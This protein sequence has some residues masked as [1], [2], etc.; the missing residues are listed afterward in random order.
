MTRVRSRLRRE[1][2]LVVHLTTTDMSLD[3]LLAPQLR[4]FADAGYDVVGMSA[5]GSH[6]A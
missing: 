6:V 3:W 2:P 5:P 1:R 4:V